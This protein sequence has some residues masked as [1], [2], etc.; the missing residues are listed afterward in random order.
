M[1]ASVHLVCGP[2]GSGKTS[3]LL[4]RYRSVARS[5]VGGALWVA[6]TR[7]AAEEIRPRLVEEDKPLLAATVFTFQDLAEEVIRVNDPAARPLTN[8]QR[9]LLADDIVADLHAGGQLSHFQR[10]A[11]TRG[12]AEAVFSFL[13]ELKRNEIWPDHLDRVLHG[14][15]GGGDAKDRQCARIYAEYQARLIRQNLYDL[16]GRFWYARDLLGRGRRRPFE[17]VQAV[18]VDGFTEFT[19]VQHEILENFCAWADELWITLPDEAGDDRAE[20]FGR[21]RATAL[22][23]QR[24]RPQLERLEPVH[25]TEPGAEGPPAGLGHLECQLFRPLRSVELGRDAEGVRRIQAPGVLGE[26]RMVAREV[27]HILGSGVDAGEILVTLRELGPYADLIPEVFAE[28]GIPV[29]VEGTEPLARNPAVAALLRAWRLPDED[30]PFAGTTAILRSTYFR[31]DWPEAAACP[32]LALQAEALLRLVGEHGGRTAYLQAVDRWADAPPAALE[33]ER[34]E[35]LRH[36]RTHELARLCRPFLRRFF[37]AWDGVPSRATTAAHAAALRRLAESLGLDRAAAERARDAAALSRLWAELE[38]WARLETRLHGAEPVRDAG[39]FWRVLTASAAEAGL[40]RTPRGPGRVRV[41]S[42]AFARGVTAPYVFVMGLGE[43]SFPRL[44]APAPFFEE[45]ERQAFRQAGLDFTC[46]DD[47][48]PDEM[49]LFYQ[50]VTRARR[51]LVFSYPAADEKGQGLLPSSFLATALDC[52]LP[53]AVPV[54]SRRMLIEGYDRDEPLSPAELRVYLAARWA[55]RPGRQP[56]TALSPDL[57]ANLEAAERLARHRFRERHYGR[58]DGLLRDPAVLAD[59]HGVVGPDKV[60]SPTALEDYIACPFRFFLRH[61]LRLEPLDEPRAEIEGTRR[62]QAFHRALARLHRQ[63]REAGVDG[64]SEAVE[65]AL[66]RE[67]DRAVEEYAARAGPASQV[68]WR[69]EGQRLRRTAA[70]YRPH[71]S[72]FLEPWLPHQVAPQPHFFEQGFG[73]PPADG[74]EPADP[75]VI[76]ADGVEVRLGGRI[77]RVDVAPLEDGLGF[78]VID[79]KTGRSAY[80]TG[81]ELRSFERLQLTLY[82]LAVERVLL[83]GQKARPLGLAYWLVADSGPRQALPPN[84]RQPT[85]WL[86]DAGPWEAVRAR[87]EQWVATLVRHMRE[88]SFPLKP[89]SADCTE[90]CDFGQVCRIS[91]SRSLEKSWD[92][93]LPQ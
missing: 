51:L 93:P 68:L 42:A 63:L 1:T 66:R 17:A 22:R 60:F 36:R 62:G 72:R 88:G 57:V 91:Q 7:R 35:E 55:H 16:E 59:L 76:S 84:P 65:E 45:P 61:V 70:R 31:P 11:D 6:P 5:M 12:F 10:I 77:D 53:G 87:L 14:R 27:K 13:A 85:S 81:A 9:R 54:Q 69:L 44:V 50:V 49:L 64:P 47:L 33:D 4:L 43:R 41:L 48:L 73:M 92:L 26:T 15:P 32:D 71:W 25:R 8:V 90:T 74:E 40:A 83:R 30:W 2:A 3:R 23:L 52:F 79:Y 38:G 18:F 58:Y 24:L 39:R 46:A 56:H 19:R 20:L 86:A 21:P 34:A 28:Y 78:W 67:L 82:A 29:D 80:Y 75:L 37:A 89:R